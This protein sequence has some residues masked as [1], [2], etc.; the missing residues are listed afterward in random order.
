[1][2]ANITVRP[3]HPDDAAQLYKIVTH[4]QVART[5]LQLPSMEL[6]QTEEW[7]RQMDECD[8][9]MGRIERIIS[10]EQAGRSLVCVRCRGRQWT[11]RTRHLRP[12]ADLAATRRSRE[13]MD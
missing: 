12:A 10:L 9:R 6:S 7:I 8:G 4:P 1:M 3:V 13:V 5:L 11:T 2:S